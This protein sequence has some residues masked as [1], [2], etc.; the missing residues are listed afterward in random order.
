MRHEQQ[1]PERAAHTSTPLALSLPDI[2]AE[3][4]WF[5]RFAASYMDDPS[6][7]LALKLRHT[8]R[9]TLVAA[10]ITA[11]LDLPAPVRRAALRAALLHDVGRFPQFRQWRTFKDAD[12]VN[13][14]HLGM[15]VLREAD[16]LRDVPHD[17]RRTVI[18]AV[19]LH[20]RHTLPGTLAEPVGTVTRIVR[21]ADKIDILHI[22]SAELARPEPSPEVLLRV[23]RE[24][25]R[26]TPAVAARIMAGH[27]PDYSELR[28]V[29]DFIMLLAA[30]PRDL[31]FA[32]SRRLVQ[33]SG[34]I[35]SLL[36]RLPHSPEPQAVRRALLAELAAAT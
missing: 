13:H 16:A 4:A 35:P 2:A 17:I 21:D 10:H 26:W 12:S 23:A 25:E 9:V 20:N 6:G 11:S 33:E 15:R 27:V 18:A 24:P 32:A 8:E 31:N 22:F 19:G 29:N 34:D 30:W 36:E 5:Y 3:A 7:P 28:Y 14:G 1:H